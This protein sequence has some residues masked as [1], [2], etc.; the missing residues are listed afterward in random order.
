MEVGYI[1]CNLIWEIMLD[2]YLATPNSRLEDG[3]LDK[4]CRQELPSD[5]WIIMKARGNDKDPI[6]MHT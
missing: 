2:L 4:P 6:A 5:L 3:L 1:C